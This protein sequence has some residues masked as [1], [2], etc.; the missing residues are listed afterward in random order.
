M[1]PVRLVSGTEDLIRRTLGPAIEVGSELLP[2][3]W[4][5]Y[6][7][8]AQLESSVLN[9]AINAR[10]AMPAGGRLTLATRNRSFAADDPDRHP[11]LAPGDYVEI[12]VT[13]TG[14]GMAAEVAKRAFEPFYTTKETGKGTGLGL[15]MV[16]GFAEQSGGVATIDSAPGRGTTVRVFF[17]RSQM[18]GALASDG[19]GEVGELPTGTETVLVVDDDADVRA[20]AASALR[21]LGYRVLEAGN[22]H[23][24]LTTL[25]READV[26]LLLA[27]L[28]L[29]GGMPGAEL[30]AR[31]LGVRAQ[32]KVLHTTAFSQPGL[33]ELSA[34]AGTDL[35]HKPYAI[36]ELARRVRAVLD[37]E[38][39]HGQ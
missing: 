14:V 30:A 35:L 18:P 27:D 16:Y 9:L 2:D 25:A 13:D 31:A 6:A 1:S 29:P 20:T 22:G 34:P 19:D 5:I 38:K 12:S 10:D 4:P 37:R 36:G 24:A 28:I 15:S 8:A 32:L 39:T 26:A 21:V 3:T 11:K 33:R 23:A 17:P 7:D